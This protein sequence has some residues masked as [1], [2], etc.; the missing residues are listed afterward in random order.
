VSSATSIKSARSPEPART[1]LASI[2][3]ASCGSGS[4]RTPSSRRPAGSAASP[5]HRRQ[6]S[7]PRHGLRRGRR[8]GD[9]QKQIEF[10]DDKAER[11]DRDGRAHP[12]QKNPLIGGVAAV[13]LDHRGRTYQGLCLAARIGPLASMTT[14]TGLAMTAIDLFYNEAAQTKEIIGD[15]KPA[16]TKTP[17]SPSPAACS[18]RSGIRECF[19]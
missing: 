16:M 1:S 17:T 15:F 12:S 19:E 6:T 5:R 4:R 2:S 9:P 7:C 3:R 14:F 8:P 10:R 13:T 18:R 11:H